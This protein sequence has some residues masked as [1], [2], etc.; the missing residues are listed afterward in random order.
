M[1][2]EFTTY[3]KKKKTAAVKRRALLLAGSEIG[4]KKQLR[5]ILWF[6]IRNVRNAKTALRYIMVKTSVILF[7]LV[8]H[9]FKLTKFNYRKSICKYRKHVRLLNIIKRCRFSTFFKKI[10]WWIFRNRLIIG[11]DVLLHRTFHL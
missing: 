2:K 5:R 7:M 8:A 11:P 4:L 3:S 9:L 1:N 10:Y 6:H